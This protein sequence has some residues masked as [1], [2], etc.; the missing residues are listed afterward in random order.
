M[1]RIFDE[2]IKA[3]DEVVDL[4][5]DVDSDGLDSVSVAD[6]DVAGLLTDVLKELKIVNIQLALMTDN[7][8]EHSEV[9]V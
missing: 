8:L 9:E 7:E 1:T 2:R 3:I 5:A 4:G 6:T